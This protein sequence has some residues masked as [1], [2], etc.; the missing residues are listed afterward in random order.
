MRFSSAL[1]DILE[2]IRQESIINE[3][4]IGD[5]QTLRNEIV[6]LLQ[7]NENKKF[8]GVAVVGGMKPAQLLLTKYAGFSDYRSAALKILQM[9][10]QMSSI[11]APGS[12]IGDIG[13]LQRIMA[14][15]SDVIVKI[16]QTRPLLSFR[17][18]IYPR[19]K[20]YDLV[21]FIRDISLTDATQQAYASGAE[22][23]KKSLFWKENI[24]KTVIK[25]IIRRQSI[26]DRTPLDK[27][28]IEALE[29]QIYKN[30]GL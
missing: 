21:S 11:V 4:R 30:N 16:D 2:K 20:G 5:L 10:M 14:I 19:L 29:K 25:E 17:D 26:T 28:E 7:K 24:R 8:L 22:Q 15:V 6:S 3:D 27:G 18:D 12:G 13:Y 9:N 1:D 23:D